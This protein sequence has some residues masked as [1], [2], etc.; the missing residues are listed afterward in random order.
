MQHNIAL[1]AIGSKRQTVSRASGTLESWHKATLPEAWWHNLQ[2]S[3]QYHTQAA[4]RVATAPAESDWV[5]DGWGGAG[6]TLYYL[7][8]M[9]LRRLRRRY[10]RRR[11]GAWVEARGNTWPARGEAGQV[12]QYRWLADG[13]GDGWWSTFVING[14]ALPL[15]SLKVVG[16]V[17]Y[18]SGIL[19][20]N[21]LPLRAFHKAKDRFPFLFVHDVWPLQNY[22]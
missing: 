15:C 21:R 5:S 6:D 18:L 19:K 16:L 4:R 2:H 10:D 17:L 22:H 1:A 20:H 14:A 11:C 13:D 12:L 8:L 9:R 7:L 3:R